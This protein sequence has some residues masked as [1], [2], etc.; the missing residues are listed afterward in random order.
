MNLFLAPKKQFLGLSFNNF[1]QNFKPYLL[2]LCFMLPIILLACMSP[3]FHN[4]Y[5]LYRPPSLKLWLLFELVYLSQ[6]FSIEFFFRGFGLFRMEKI[7]PGKAVF[8]MTLPYALIHIHKPLP[9]AIGAIFAGI[10]LGLL[11]LK[12]KSIWP[13]VLTHCIV[14]LAAD[15]FSLYFSGHFRSW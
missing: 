7:I 15:I 3:A 14:A 4:F 8:I 5:P 9:E 1:K 11:A 6:Y 2:I 13:G 12:S 10:V